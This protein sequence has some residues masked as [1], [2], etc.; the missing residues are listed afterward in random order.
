MQVIIW[1]EK[2]LSTANLKKYKLKQI[3]STIYIH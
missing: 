2:S 1:G 3:W